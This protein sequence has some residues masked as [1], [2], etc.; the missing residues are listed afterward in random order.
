MRHADNLW[1]WDRDSV[2]CLVS[3]LTSC[4]VSLARIWRIWGPS[5]AFVQGRADGEAGV[6]PGCTPGTE[7]PRDGAPGGPGSPP[8]EGW[9]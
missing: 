3:R 8:P 9:R 5:L 7:F 6:S 2:T 1:V 4:L